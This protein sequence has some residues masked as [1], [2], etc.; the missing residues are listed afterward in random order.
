MLSP[1]WCLTL[2]FVTLVP[3]AAWSGERSPM[4][5]PSADH[6]QQRADAATL[7]EE[8]VIAEVEGA[9][10]RAYTRQDGTRISEYSRHGR[11][12]MI[13]VKPP[14]DLPAYYLYDEHGD[15][16]FSR[17]L[18]GGYRQIAPPQWVVKEF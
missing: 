14:G 1:R 5:P 17:R 7:S 11:V 3:V 18:P 2:I 12:Y 9:D 8:Q 6:I 16:Q 10:I 4:P 13:K 15:G